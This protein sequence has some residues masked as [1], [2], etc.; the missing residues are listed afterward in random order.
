[1]ILTFLAYESKTSYRR[2]LW[3]TAAGETAKASYGIY[4]ICF[5]LQDLAIVSIQVH[6]HVQILFG[7]KINLATLVF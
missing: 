3:S 6:I 4:R 5:W 1:V 2:F 7:V